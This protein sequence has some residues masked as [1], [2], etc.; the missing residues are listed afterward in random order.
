M[1]L[2]E[3]DGRAWRAALDAVYVA[4]AKKDPGRPALE[5]VVIAC[6]STLRLVACDEY[7]LHIAVIPGCSPDHEVLVNAVALH[8]VKIKAGA[9]VCLDLDDTGAVLSVNGQELPTVNERF[10]DFEQIIP[11]HFAWSFT[12]DAE[13]L[14][15]SL[16][17]LSPI[18]KNLV[19]LVVLDGN[20]ISTSD[21]ELGDASCR[22]ETL[23]IVTGVA[24]RLG[25]NWRYLRDALI[26]ETQVTV[27]GNTATQP[28]LIDGL[29]ARRVIMP[30]EVA[31]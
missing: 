4:A 2:C 23:H 17:F 27:S 25:V 8:K 22:L 19:D 6:A 14:R 29:V 31:R 21:P 11:L 28:I 18:A 3:V 9:S 13:E 10:P 1:K 7:R 24:P 15:K 30:M 16:R 20:V 26:G 12:I 5:C